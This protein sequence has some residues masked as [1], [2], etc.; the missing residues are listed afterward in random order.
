MEL[1]YR[2]IFSIKVII[3][4]IC[5]FICASFV[6]HIILRKFYGEIFEKE[7]MFLLYHYLQ[8]AQLS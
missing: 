7:T 6:G 5:I 1:S 3:V 2:K 8:E 4:I